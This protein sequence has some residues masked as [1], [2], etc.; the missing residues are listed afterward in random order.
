VGAS[1]LANP[2]DQPSKCRLIHPFR[3]QARSHTS[4][5]DNRLEIVVGRQVGL[6]A[7]GQAQ[8]AL[9]A[10]AALFHFGAGVAAQVTVTE[11]YRGVLRN[12][13]QHTHLATDGV[14]DV[15]VTAET[16]R[17]LR[18]LGQTGR[19][20]TEQFGAAAHRVEQVVAA[21]QIF[22]AQFNAIVR[23]GN[24][25]VGGVVAALAVLLTEAHALGV[26]AVDGPGD[27]GVA[28][29]VVERVGLVDLVAGLA[30]CQAGEVAGVV[31]IGRDAGA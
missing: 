17:I 29:V 13:L 18:E 15:A 22:L 26:V 16:W 8:R 27:V 14:T 2:V 11:F 5:C 10:A 23:A 7:A 24:V 3:E 9:F 30:E 1:L 19:G 12:L 25:V 6:R 20:A 31:G 4:N 21:E 28:E